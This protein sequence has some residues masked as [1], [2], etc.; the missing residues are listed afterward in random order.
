MV[1]EYRQEDNLVVSQVPAPE[2]PLSSWVSSEAVDPEA[3]GIKRVAAGAFLVSLLLAAL[4]GW[5]A[6]I[7][8]SLALMADSLDSA[9]IPALRK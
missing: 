1:Q 7:S 2:E 4:K 9:P 3:R 8:G 5:L 6:H